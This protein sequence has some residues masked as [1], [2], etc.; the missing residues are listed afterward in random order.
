M[1]DQNE[2]PEVHQEIDIGNGVT[3]TFVEYD[4]EVVGLNEAHKDKHGNKCFGYVAFDGSQYT[5]KDAPKWKV[6][7][8]DP[9]T[10]EPSILCRKCGNHGFIRNGRWVAA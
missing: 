7:S 1:S 8:K 6:I 10:L 3:I 9:L 2:W 5:P 4:G